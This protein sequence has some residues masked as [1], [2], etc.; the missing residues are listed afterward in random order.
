MYLSVNT[1]VDTQ[2]TM[3]GTAEQNGTLI[4]NGEADGSKSTPSEPSLLHR[5]LVNPPQHVVSG[6]GI[7]LTLSDGRRILD[8]CA[9]A[10][11]SNIGHG[12]EEVTEAIA[13]QMSQVSFVHTQAYTTDSAEELARILVGHRPHG[14]CRAYFIC[15]GSEATDAA[16]KFARQYFFEK[17]EVQR[18]NIVSRRQSYHGN[19]LGA[20]SVGSNVAR[21]IPYAGAVLLENV[22]FVSPTYEY[23]DRLAGETEEQYATR[24]V[25]EL[26]DEFQRL[27]PETVIAFLA[28]TVGG[29]TAGCLTAPKGYFEGVRRVC[30]K[31][32][33]LLILDEVMCGSGRSGSFFAFEQE[34]DDVRPDLVTL[35]KGLGA[36][37]VPIAG[38]LMHEKIVNT[39]RNGSGAVAHGHTYQAHPVSCAAAVAVQRIMRRE[40]LISQCAAKGK[41][42]EAR[43][44]SAFA[45]AKH[46]GNLRGR[47]L[48]WAVEF[49]S[50]SN[51]GDGKTPFA[52]GIG[53]GPRVVEAAFAL[54][55]AVYPGTG[56]A[57]GLCGDHIIVAPPLTVTL[58]EVD[59]LVDLLRRAY[60][61]VEQDVANL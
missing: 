35:G 18:K 15:S 10:A 41:F 4:S 22:S 2:S 48:F 23:R 25:N 5:S 14:L 30:D 21:K 27:G 12:N 56:T 16:L 40:D 37:F 43:L 36:G 17:G 51:L 60:D 59:L 1:D 53:F 42:L 19:T 44:R 26:D 39:I 28:E 31:Y 13:R 45:S 54:G 55:L 32:G 9:G 50:S 3:S 46:A 33:I 58:E 49:V 6:S 38:V 57:D 34:G 47:G 29:A 20:M 7:Y 52:P 11:V 61:R 24:L 8:G